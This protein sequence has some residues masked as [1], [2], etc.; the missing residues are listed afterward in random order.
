[1]NIKNPDDERIIPGK[2]EISEPNRQ[3]SQAD[4]KGGKEAL[5]TKGLQKETPDQAR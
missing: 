1:V 5:E 4:L 3:Q 2:S